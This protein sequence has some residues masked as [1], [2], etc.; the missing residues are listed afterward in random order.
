MEPLLFSSM[1]YQCFGFSG[2]DN[3]IEQHCAT[4]DE[5]TN[6]YMTGSRC[7][8]GAIC[9]SYYTV[10][11][12]DKDDMLPYHTHITCEATSQWNCYNY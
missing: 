3:N 4:P 12:E 1:T 7:V 8:Q 5:Y 2:C 10:Y 9:V 11:C 6:S